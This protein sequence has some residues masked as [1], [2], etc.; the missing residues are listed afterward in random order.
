MEQITSTL[1][2]LILQGQYKQFYVQLFNYYFPYGLIFWAIGFVLFIAVQ[3]KTKNLAYAG[4][5]AA[6]Y[7]EVISSSGLIVN[8]FAVMAM[9]YFGIILGLACGYYIY[10]MVKG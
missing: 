4:I 3:I 8:A 2:D 10:R 7:F 5:V 6:L 9:K 1:W